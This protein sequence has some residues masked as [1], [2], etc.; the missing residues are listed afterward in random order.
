[1]RC[2]GIVVDMSVTHLLVRTRADTIE[3]CWALANPFDSPAFEV[4]IELIDIAS[5][6]REMLTSRSPLFYDNIASLSGDGRFVAFD[7]LGSDPPVAVVLDLDT[8][9]R[10]LE[11]DP[12]ATGATNPGL[13]GLNQ[14]GS[15]LLEGARPT[16]VWDV[17]RG[18]VIA[19]FDIG[20]FAV[21]GP[22]GRTV[23]S[24]DRDGALRNWDAAT[25]EELWVVRGVGSGRVSVNEE[26][27]VLVSDPE[28]GEAALV[29]ARLRGEVAAVETCRGGWL[30]AAAQSLNVAGGVA[31]FHGAC[32][33]PPDPFTAHVIDLEE[34]AIL[35]TIPN[36]GGQVVRLSPDGTRLVAQEASGGLTGPVA[37]TDVRTGETL[38][39]LEGLCR[40]SEELTL[41]GVPR[42]ET[43]DCGRFPQPPFPLWAWSLEW[44]PDGTMIAAVDDWAGETYLA[45]WDAETGRLLFTEERAGFTTFTPDS[46]R[47]LTSPFGE[48]TMVA[49]S[50]ETWELVQETPFEESLA[51]T[52]GLGLAGFSADGETLFSVGGLFGGGGGALHWFDADTL[53]V[54]RSK[55]RIHEGSPKSMALSPE[56]TLLATGAS[57]GF[58]RVWDTETGSLVHEIPIGD[59]EVQGVAFVNDR[60]LAVTPQEGN[61]LIFTIDTEELLRIVRSSLTRGFSQTECERFNFG[62]ECPSLEE[63]R[64]G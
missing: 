7:D 52:G 6:E 21:F 36:V 53:E 56:A 35:Y 50:T 33:N 62:E 11:Y 59:T 5:G 10:V 47:L 43:G 22:S 31:V 25:G 2:G 20:P 51:G 30:P 16:Q 57:D 24:S 23:Y 60:D 54:L 15:F 17:A 45:V 26:G 46:N 19:S 58:V 55:T 49:F 18:Q 39:E 12:L 40:W 14:D 9:E 38:V 63:L 34:P 37:V 28:A 41:A 32:T 13:R 48:Q 64:R 27:L 1:G 8:G 29:D 61:L 4:G 44:S 3:S 42:E